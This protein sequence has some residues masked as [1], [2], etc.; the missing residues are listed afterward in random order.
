[1]HIFVGSKAPWER[2]TDGLPQ[3]AAFPPGIDAH[4]LPDPPPLAPPAPG[5]LRGSCL[6]GGAAYELRG[7]I[8]AVRSCHCSRCRKARAAAHASN[9]V[10]AADGLR[11]LRGEDLL[12]SYKVPEARFFTQVFC[13]VCGGKLPRVD[14][15]RGIAVL[16]LGSLDDDPGR[17]PEHHIFVGSKAPWFEITDGL[18][19][20]TEASP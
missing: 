16:P 19:Q 1:M 13:R 12:Q 17:G 20:Y 18:P 8:R 5:A 15:D 2:I 10:G 3:H 4:V 6:C 14:F 7:E 11:W 9:L